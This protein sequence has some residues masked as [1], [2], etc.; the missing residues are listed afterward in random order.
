MKSAI[1]EMF[2]MHVYTDKAV[3]VGDV[4]D[5]VINVDGK[6]IESLAVSKL[7]PE[8]IELKNFKGIKIPY[9]IILA[10]GDVVIIRHLVGSLE[11]KED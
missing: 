1:T 11:K 9:R 3:Y 6:K 4:D 8:L 5:V 7:N 2:G 10:V